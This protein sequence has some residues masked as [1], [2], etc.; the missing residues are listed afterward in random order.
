MSPTAISHQI[1]LRERHCGQ[2]LFRRW[3]RPL[4]LTIP[5]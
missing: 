5:P 1:N 4:T 2:S 3:P